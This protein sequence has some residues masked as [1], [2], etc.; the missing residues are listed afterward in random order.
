[1]RERRPVTERPKENRRSALATLAALLPYLW[2]R[3]E[4]ELRLRVA[5]ALA[6]LLLAK[7]VNVTVPLFYKG[8][9][10]ALTPQAGGAVLALP[11]ALIV[12]YGLVRVLAQGFGELRDTIFAKVA[13]RAV[14]ASRPSSTCIA[15]ACASTWN[16]GPAASAGRS[17]AEGTSFSSA[18]CSSSCR[19]CQI[20]LVT[21]I[22]WGLYDRPW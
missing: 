16:G 3:G 8:A 15:S 12:G 21:A 14:P 2:P 18:C 6:C 5:G 9:V 10:D 22:L 1:M 11:V 20:A 17:S 13:V 4:T 7:L 19:R